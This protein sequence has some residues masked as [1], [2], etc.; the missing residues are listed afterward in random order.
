MIRESVKQEELRPGDLVFF[1]KKG[2]E[3]KIIE[4][5]GLVYEIQTGKL[6]VVFHTRKSAGKALFE[7]LNQA[8]W[9][10]SPSNQLGT[11]K[12]S[13]FGRVNFKETKKSR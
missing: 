3:D 12:I 10:F 6:P 11:R 1:H 7:D 5:V 9:L 13:G 2:D 4:H 8:E